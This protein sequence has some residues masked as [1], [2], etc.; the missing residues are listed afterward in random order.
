MRDLSRQSRE[1]LN[2]RAARIR[3]KLPRPSFFLDR[4]RRQSACETVRRLSSE[5][6]HKES[7]EWV[8]HLYLPRRQPVYEL[9]VQRTILRW[10]KAAHKR[11]VKTNMRELRRKAFKSVRGAE[12]ERRS[13]KRQPERNFIMFLQIDYLNATG[14]LP[15]VTARK[16]EHRD[17]TLR[18]S[19][20]IEMV[21]KCLDLLGAEKV[22]VIEQINELQA[23]RLALS[24]R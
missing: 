16:Y 10:I 17:R 13:P 12:P 8:P 4:A 2:K 24:D 21:Q 20:F 23:R 11:G 18:P 19:P 9:E 14:R 3:L 1:F 22:D 5:G 15:P 6:G 7:G